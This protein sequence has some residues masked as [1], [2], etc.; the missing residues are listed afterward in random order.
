M[1]IVDELARKLK[2]LNNIY[3]VW[4][5]NRYLRVTYVAPDWLVVWDHR[6]TPPNRYDIKG[7]G[8][9]EAVCRQAA[10]QLQNLSLDDRDSF[11]VMPGH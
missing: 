10:D 5:F 1:H 7:A 2:S 3:S 8:N 4:R 9:H 11:L 6:Q